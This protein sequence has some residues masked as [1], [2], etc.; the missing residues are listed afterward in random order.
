M[1]ERGSEAQAMAYIVEEP[2]YL[3][4]CGDSTDD[5][6]ARFVADPSLI[7][8]RI[9]DDFIAESAMIR[10]WWC[11][12]H[13]AQRLFPCGERMMTRGRADRVLTNS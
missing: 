4:G 12:A 13:L 10:R 6:V 5:V 11:T 8:P 3:C 2:V 9:S 7:L 1:R